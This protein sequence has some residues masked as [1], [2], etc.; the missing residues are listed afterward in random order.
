MNYIIIVLLKWIVVAERKV[1]EALLG[2]H[3][4]VCPGLDVLCVLA[5][6][7]VCMSINK[8]LERKNRNGASS[9]E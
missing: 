7:R 3:F 8:R 2:C 6:V 1:C 9:P 5:Q 4:Q